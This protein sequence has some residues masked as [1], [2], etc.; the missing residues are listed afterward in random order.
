MATVIGLV[1]VGFVVL[2]IIGLIVKPET[3]S[4][5][6]T[7]DGNVYKTVKIGNQVWMAE[8]LRYKIDG[9]WCYE[10]NESNCQK[11]GRLYEWEAAKK[12]YPSGWHLPTRDDWNVLVQ[13]AGGENIVGKKLKTES[14]WNGTDNYGF[15]AVPGG[16]RYTD[17]DFRRVNNFGGWWT[18]TEGRNSNAYRRGMIYSDYVEECEDDVG[19]GYSAR[20]VKNINS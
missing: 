19:M 17:G 7:R 12:A 9:S 4:F 13:Y 3:S 8:N 1:V 2:C 20:Y 11:Y 5:T 14:G 10:N 15:S 16:C 18:A 6:D